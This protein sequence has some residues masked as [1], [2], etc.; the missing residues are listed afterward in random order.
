MRESER[1]LR[2]IIDTVPT[3]LWSA[4]PTGEPTYV[5]RRALDYG[6]MRF[7]EFKHGGWEVFIHPADFP[8]TMKAFGHAIN[9]GISYETVTSPASHALI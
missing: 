4:D 2:Q 7:E 1:Q 8:G 6:G 9:T 3:L 5:N